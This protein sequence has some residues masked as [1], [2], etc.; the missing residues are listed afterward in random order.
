MYFWHRV[1]TIVQASYNILYHVCRLKQEVIYQMQ[2][3]VQVHLVGSTYVLQ[4]PHVS[5]WHRLQNTV[6][7]FRKD[8]RLVTR[9]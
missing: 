9:A 7:D 2:G 3:T 1:A 4:Y 8:K 6:F 5:I